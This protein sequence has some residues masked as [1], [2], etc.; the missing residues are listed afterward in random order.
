MRHI[1]C[2]WN[3][4]IKTPEPLLQG[5]VKGLNILHTPS[6]R[7]PFF[8]GVLHPPLD[9]L[10]VDHLQSGAS[11]APDLFAQ[12]WHNIELVLECFIWQ[13]FDND[14]FYLCRCRLE[15]LVAV[16]VRDKILLDVL[17]HWF[18]RAWLQDNAKVD[19]GPCCFFLIETRSPACATKRGSDS[20][21]WCG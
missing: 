10:P 16:L 6:A 9:T 7:V 17:Q 20:P 5:R 8:D 12:R 21:C 11:A 15:L 14:L 3:N 13:L 2:R 18:P 19:G 1:I 4:Y